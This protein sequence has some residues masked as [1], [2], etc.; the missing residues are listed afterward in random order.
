MSPLERAR[1]HHEV[2]RR[3]DAHV[4]Y[5]AIDDN[6]RSN[7]ES[8]LRFSDKA[9]AEIIWGMETA[10]VTSININ[11][12]CYF[13]LPIQQSNDNFNNSNRS[14]L[15]SMSMDIFLVGIL[16]SG[17]TLRSVCNHSGRKITTIWIRLTA[18]LLYARLWMLFFALIF[19]RIFPSQ[20]RNPCKTNKWLSPTIPL[21]STSMLR[22]LQ[23]PCI[24]ELEYSRSYRGRRVSACRSNQMPVKVTSAAETLVLRN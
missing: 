15:S 12:G 2:K 19:C 8:L 17:I 10:K 16:R 9:R 23:I 6:Q 1:N 7:N 3:R 11:E 13:S 24:A 14:L 22:F 21:S 5:L 4:S 20:L 18:S